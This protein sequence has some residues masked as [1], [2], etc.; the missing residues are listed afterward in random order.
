MAM[1]LQY[2]SA[3]KA[4]G[5]ALPR[6]LKLLSNIYL[7]SP[8]VAHQRGAFGLKWSETAISSF[9]QTSIEWVSSAS[10][11]QR[12]SKHGLVRDQHLVINILL[13]RNILVLHQAGARDKLAVTGTSSSS[14]KTI[15]PAT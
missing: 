14:K 2:R 6:L 13:L 7:K 10:P 15:S 3:G 8:I 4:S 12:T 9:Y 5:T 1:V 11:D